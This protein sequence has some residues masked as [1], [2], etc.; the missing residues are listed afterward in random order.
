MATLLRSDGTWKCL[1]YPS[2]APR[3]LSDLSKELNTLYAD[4]FNHYELGSDWGVIHYD[5]TGSVTIVDG[6]L[7]VDSGGSGDFW[8]AS[9]TGSMVYCP[10]PVEWTAVEVDVVNVADNPG[11]VR[12]LMVRGGLEAN[13]PFCAILPDNDCSHLTIVWRDS[14]GATTGYAGD[15]TG[16]SWD[17]TKPLRL[18]L[19]RSGSTI[20]AKASYDGGATWVAVGSRAMPE[21]KYVCLCAVGDSAGVDYVVYDNFAV[22]GASSNNIIQTRDGFQLA[23]VPGSGEY[24]SPQLSLRGFKATGTPVI[25]WDA[26]ATSM[27][28]DV[29]ISL[30]GGTTWSGWQ[31]V[32]NGGP[33]PGV[34]AATNLDNVRF[35]YRLTLASNDV[36]SPV[37]SNIRIENIAGWAD[38]PYDDS[39]WVSVYDNGAYGVSPW[40]TQVTNWPDTSAHWLWDRASTSS[41]PAGD[42]YFRQKFSLA[43]PKW[44]AVAFVCDDKAELY[45]DGQYLLGN[46]NWKG[47]FA[48]TIYLPAGNHVIAIKG[49]NSTAGTAGLLVTVRDAFVGLVGSGVL[50]GSR[51]ARVFDGIK[52]AITFGLRQAR[53]LIANVYVVDIF[54]TGP[55]TR[56][57]GDYFLGVRSAM[58]QEVGTPPPSGEPTPTQ[59]RRF[60]RNWAPQLWKLFKP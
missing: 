6:R 46:A 35:K 16:L 12:T 47:V 8:Q 23:T 55:A 31:P 19:E 25:S 42:V 38:A 28:C 59:Y 53:N 26:S 32:S 10:L 30:D 58:D 56:K 29:D 13:A 57:V 52:T 27:T 41:A 40:T 54:N 49:T 36:V 7:T 14:Y 9:D 4:D 34:D 3:L 44:V 17:R 45:V 2:Q 60:P 43:E 51:L 5:G 37:V 22:F 50:T 1:G 20:T 48:N 11:Y 24:I 15:N 18:R 39:S 33:L 21:M